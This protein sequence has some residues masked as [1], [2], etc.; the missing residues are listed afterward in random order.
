MPAGKDGRLTGQPE[1]TEQSVE[2]IPTSAG[3]VV[4]ATY[5]KIRSGKPI[6][7]S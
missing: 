2:M 3:R 5:G 1:I 4:A 7:C 6:Q